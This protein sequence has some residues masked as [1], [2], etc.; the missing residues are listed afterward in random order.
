M[1]LCCE[2]YEKERLL[3]LSYLF[4]GMLIIVY[5]LINPYPAKVENLVSF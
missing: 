2:D 4:R 3:R 1:F 5:F